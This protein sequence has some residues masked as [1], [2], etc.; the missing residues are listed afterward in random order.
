MITLIMF[1]TFAFYTP[2]TRNR[3]E[4]MASAPCIGIARDPAPV[5]E[6]TPTATPTQPAGIYTNPEA[7]Q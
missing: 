7:A 1:L 4:C 2:D 5:V 6:V 3:V